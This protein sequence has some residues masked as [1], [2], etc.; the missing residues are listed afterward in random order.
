MV[1]TKSEEDYIKF[2]YQPSSLQEQEGIK[3]STIAKAFGYT[4]QSVNE[5][6][7]R[8]NEK[9]LVEYFPYKGVRLTQTG[10]ELALKMIR[11]HRVWEVFL[12]E[13]LGYRWDEV[14]ALSEV[15]E[16]TNQADVIERLYHYLNKPKHCPHGNL[17]PSL[18]HAYVADTLISLELALVGQQFIVHRVED[19]PELLKF[20]S[21]LHIQLGTTLSI[22]GIDSFNELMTIEVNQ[23]SVS[24]SLKNAS[25]VFGV[26]T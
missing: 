24:I 19:A 3:I 10:L 6:I 8:L 7:K 4:E 14:H 13:K 25:K 23:S 21:S 12:F 16:H 22:Q 18:G 17:I 2:L 15:L 11:A 5:M 26:I 9:N 1:M 20:L